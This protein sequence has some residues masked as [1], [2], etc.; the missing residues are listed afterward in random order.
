MLPFLILAT[1]CCLVA[2]GLQQ[3]TVWTW[4]MGWVVLFLAA[5]IYGTNTFSGL[6]NAQTP[7]A[8]FAAFI[9]L[10][11][12]ALVWTLAAVWWCGRRGFFGR[13]R[14][15]RLDGSRPP[16][17]KPEAQAPNNPHA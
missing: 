16:P 5:G 10:G 3:R 6:Y 12:G 7:A 11:G 17:Q 2:V 9:Y 15:V 13:R 4:Y 1:M 14:S 8:T